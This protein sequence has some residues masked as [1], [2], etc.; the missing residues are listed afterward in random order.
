MLPPLIYSW[1]GILYHRI[2]FMSVYNQST[3]SLPFRENPQLD[4]QCLRHFSHQA[5]IQHT[6]RLILELCFVY[7]GDLLNQR[8]AGVLKASRR[9]P[10]Q[11]HMS[12]HV[13]GFPL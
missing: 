10:G 4:L 6:P 1:H 2:W 8:D 3:L 5:L 13:H 9:L 11:Q 12:W 7:R